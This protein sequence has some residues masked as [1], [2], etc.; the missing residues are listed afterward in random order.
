M[1]LNTILLCVKINKTDILTCLN[2]SKKKAITTKKGWEKQV[3]SKQQRKITV[4][5]L[6]QFGKM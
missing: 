5:N 1:L 3:K 4:L 2:R 6:N